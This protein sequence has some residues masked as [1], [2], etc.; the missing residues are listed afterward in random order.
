MGKTARWFGAALLV[1]LATSSA[2]AADPIKVGLGMSLTG[3]LAGN[4]K[5]ALIAMQIWRTIPMPKV[6]SWAV[7]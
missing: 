6:D 3:K 7:R 4:G 2:Q 5:P 1:A